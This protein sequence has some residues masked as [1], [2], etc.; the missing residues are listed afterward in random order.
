MWSAPQRRVISVA[1]VVRVITLPRTSVR[2]RRWPPARRR[3]SSTARRVRR[4]REGHGLVVAAADALAVGG[5][6]PGEPAPAMAAEHVL[7][8]LGIGR[9]GGGSPRRAA[10]AARPR[11][12][13]MASSRDSDRANCAAA[14]HVRKL[15]ENVS[16]PCASCAAEVLDRRQLVVQRTHHLGTPGSEEAGGAR[17]RLRARQQPPRRTTK[18]SLPW[19]GGAAPAGKPPGTPARRLVPAKRAGLQNVS[20]TWWPQTQSS[21]SRRVARKKEARF[22]NVPGAASSRVLSDQATAAPASSHRS[23]HLKAPARPLPPEGRNM[24]QP[25]QTAKPEIVVHQRSGRSS[26]F[27]NLNPSRR[28]PRTDPSGAAT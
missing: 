3:R 18:I 15:G 11:F 22:G 24:A 12:P 28:S 9:P 2:S 20:T 25:R 26:G 27:A 13:P 4:R 5:K 21:A 16:T 14:F 8:R 10:R 19:G 7:E 17:Q 6:R 1:G 23:R